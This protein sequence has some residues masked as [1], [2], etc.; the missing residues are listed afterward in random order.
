MAAATTAAPSLLHT[1]TVQQ[2]RA[3][4]N[5]IHTCFHFT[6]ILALLY[7]R[8]STLLHG[9]VPLLSWT[10]VTFS[11]L[12]F[13]LVWVFTQAFRWRPVVRSVKPENLPAKSEDLPG[14]DVF[15][16][17]ADPSKE[18]VVEVMN[19]VLSAMALDYPTEKLAVYLSDDGGAATT[20]YAMKEACGFARHW[21]PF[22]R[23]Y[24]IKTMC[25]EAYFSSL[26]DDERLLRVGDDEFMADELKIKVGIF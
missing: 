15:I 25:P 23:R 16:C 4:L 6:A 20:L 13:T 11:E 19:T 2:P 9:G 10:L 8:F 12:I 18:P 1:C 24:V 14:V 5:R 26:G 3:T 17:T 21:L 22:L 7:Y